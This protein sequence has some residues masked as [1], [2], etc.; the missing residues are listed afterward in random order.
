MLQY[1]ISPISGAVI[2]YFTNWLAI[3]MLFLPHEEKRIFGIKLPFTPGLIPKDRHKLAQKVGNVTSD[4]LLTAEILN[5][6]LQSE[7]VNEK[8]TQL[9]CELQHHTLDDILTMVA[10]ENKDAL[11]LSVKNQL[12][13]ALYNGLR[14]EALYTTCIDSA[15]E[16]VVSFLKNGHAPTD[17]ILDFFEESIRTKGIPYLFSDAMQQAINPFVLDKKISDYIKKPDEE[18]LNM[19]L[20]ENL[21]VFTRAVVSYLEDH[22]DLDH[23]LRTLTSKFVGANIGKLAGLFVN[24]DKVYDNLKQSL[25]DYFDEEDNRLIFMIKLHSFLNQIWNCELK[26]L[27][28]N[29]S[30]FLSEEPSEEPAPTRSATLKFLNE[31]TLLAV[32]DK[33]VSYARQSL[34]GDVLP[35]RLEA[36]RDA[37]T[38]FLKT[39]LKQYY[40]DALQPE[41]MK[42]TQPLAQKL[43]D[44]ILQFNLGRLSFF[45]TNQMEGIRKT[46][47]TKVAS[48]FVSSLD[49]SAIVERQIN[50]FEI[51]MTE[52]IVLSVAKKELNAITN[53]GGLLGFIIGL[54]PVL[55]QYLGIS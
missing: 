51:Q 38:A 3:K 55:L 22:A 31:S 50:S 2:G 35:T 44:L 53:V 20:S 25:V 14:N 34:G 28:D 13:A 6:H 4:Y 32:L 27:T 29:V 15:V 37:L 24:T 40:C 12:E 8:L 10:G 48:L 39:T 26:T 1:I 46:I 30:Q 11:V 23:S 42:H 43:L 7:G 33:V 18:K 9:M 47:L 5:E 52:D 45:D 49:I 21:P 19:Y 54:V 41:F 36:K 16:S 17:A